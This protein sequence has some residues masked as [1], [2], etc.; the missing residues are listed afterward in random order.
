MRKSVPPDTTQA[1]VMAFI[2]TS[3]TLLG[4]EIPQVYARYV[5]V[6]QPVEITFKILKYHFLP[7]SSN[8]N[9]EPGTA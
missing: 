1:S 9:L 3:D 7:N 4:A 8:S 6:G 2:D 5:A